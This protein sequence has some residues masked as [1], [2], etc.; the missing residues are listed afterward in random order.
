MEKHIVLLPDPRIKVQNIKQITEETL[1]ILQQNFKKED[2]EKGLIAAIEAIQT[3]LQDKFPRQG[4]AEN[5]VPNK[6]I[7][8]QD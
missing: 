6:L 7:W 3:H 1:A 2:Y 5:T 4:T 8:W